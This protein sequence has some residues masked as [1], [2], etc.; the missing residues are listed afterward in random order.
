[1]PKTVVDEV[2]ANIPVAKGCRPWWE[3]LTPSQKT[4]AREI[5]SAWKDGRLGKRKKPAAIGISK[6][7]A[8]YGVTIGY[9]GVRQWLDANEA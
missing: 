2:V 7:L 9:Q 4:I 8:R 3:R 5:L 1:M 6:T